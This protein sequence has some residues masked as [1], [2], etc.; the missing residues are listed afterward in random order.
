MTRLPG[1]LKTEPP[2]KVFFAFLGG[3]ACDL[4]AAAGRCSRIDIY[5]QDLQFIN[6]FTKK[7][8]EGASGLSN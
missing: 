1:A 4:G 2:G 6:S 3:L 5:P 7:K 8:P